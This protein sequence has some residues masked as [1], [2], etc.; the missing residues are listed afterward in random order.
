MNPL[1]DVLRL[2]LEDGMNPVKWNAD[3]MRFVK[4][5]AEETGN[6]YIWLIW[7]AVNKFKAA[8]RTAIA[9]P[10][11]IL[12]I[13]T[14]LR[15]MLF[16]NVKAPEKEIELPYSGF[17]AISSFNSAYRES[18]EYFPKEKSLFDALLTTLGKILTP[19]YSGIEDIDET[20]AHWNR[21]FMSLYY[22]NV[23]LGYEDF[24]LFAST[25]ETLSEFT[26]VMH[27]AALAFE[28]LPMEMD[29]E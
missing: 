13:V 17:M 16:L 11:E 5:K 25:A 15:D 19:L 24:L 2:L 4:T 7:H 20:T 27:F 14:F 28:V 18:A 26:R 23:F 8:K 10:S 29:D 6:R 3:T 9:Q 21:F 22:K 12:F 1:N